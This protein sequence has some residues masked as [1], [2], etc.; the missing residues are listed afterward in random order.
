MQTRSSEKKWKRYVDD[1]LEVVKRGTVDKLTEFWNNLD[2]SG[3]IK[4]TYEVG[5]RRTV[6]IFRLAAEENK[7]WRV[8]VV[9]L[10]E[11]YPRYI[12]SKRPHHSVHSCMRCGLIINDNNSIKLNKSYRHK[13]TCKDK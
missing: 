11:T 9:S 8:K 1:T 13:L 10:Q 12:Y 6:A 3:S 5:N 7:Q 4:F 2:D